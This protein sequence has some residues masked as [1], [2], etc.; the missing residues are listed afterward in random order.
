MWFLNIKKI[1]KL[2][3]GSFNTKTSFCIFIFFDTYLI[4]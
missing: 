1:L 3:Q 4:K 2:Q